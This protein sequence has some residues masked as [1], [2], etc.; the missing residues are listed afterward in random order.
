L[1]ESQVDFSFFGTHELNKL[2]QSDD[3][4]AGYQVLLDKDGGTQALPQATFRFKK[5][6]KPTA[7][8]FTALVNEFYFEAYH[9]AK[10]LKR[11]ELWLVKSRDWGTKELL[12]RMMEWR[13]QARHQWGCNTHYLG[14]HMRDWIEPAI[15][16]SLHATF[17]H[18]DS[19]DSWKALE[20]TIRL[21]RQLAT[22]TALLL[23]YAYPETTDRGI[24]AF[25]AT[26]KAT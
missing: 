24:C 19:S 12:L 15:W 3:L 2:A 25:I 14:K 22:E 4:D 1:R 21:F 5:Q 7:E 6:S 26:L 20:A 8:Q 17:A 9:I 23:D 10:Y 16:Q 18:F 11:E 13:E